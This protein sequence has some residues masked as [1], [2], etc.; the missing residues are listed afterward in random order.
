MSRC[1]RAAAVVLAVA[2]AACGSTAPTAAPTT[3]PA[4]APTPSP[5]PALAASWTSPASG[6]MLT[7]ST[8]E[9][10]AMASTSPATAS[11]E[12]VSFTVAWG[13][14][15]KSACTAAKASGGVWSCTADMW[16]LGA[17]VGRVT[18]AFDV[19]DG[20]GAV[21][22][23]PA[24][25]RTVDYDP[26]AAAPAPCPW[27]DAIAGPGPPDLAERAAPGSVPA[28]LPAGL[29][30]AGAIVFAAALWD[31]WAGPLFTVGPAGGSCAAGGGNYLVLETR[32][33]AGR[34]V[35]SVD[36][37]GDAGGN[38]WTSCP[39]IPAAR[40]AALANPDTAQFL[41][42]FCRAV[43]GT[44]T[45]AVPTGLP[46]FW[47]ALVLPQTAS[48]GAMAGPT[49]YTF[50][51]GDQAPG[52]TSAACAPGAS[53]RTCLAVLAFQVPQSY[54][55]G[56]LSASQREAVDARIAGALGVAWP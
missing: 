50:L 41:D 26:W 18:L 32:D 49:L 29:V 24:G 38:L 52:S 31:G 14:T 5:A 28:A 16:R 34:P 13:S 9:L 8:L 11:V 10:S 35:A 23:A 42:R 36:F 1:A 40:A 39:Y 19:T 44:R 22:R 53:A 27:S 43:P 56:A 2:L 4:I 21:T 33:A 6:A 51:D 47:A 37:P 48:A 3:A 46:R 20:S 17:P 25:T 7:T 30:P 54:G 55:G 12:S 45:V 15:T